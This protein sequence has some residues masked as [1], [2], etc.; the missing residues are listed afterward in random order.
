VAH[1]HRADM[2]V[3]QAAVQVMDLQEVLL[4]DTAANRK[5]SPRPTKCSTCQ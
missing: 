5:R 2:A 4:E 3:V 1:H